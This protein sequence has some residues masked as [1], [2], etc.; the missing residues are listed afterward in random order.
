MEVKSAGLL[1]K[2]LTKHLNSFCAK[3]ELRLLGSNAVRGVLFP[4]DVDTQCIVNDL[5]ADELA[6]HIQSAVRDLGDAFITE[7][8]I[9]IEKT[10]Y[11]WS[12]AELLKG[13]KGSMSLSQALRQ[14]DGIVK[15]DMIIPVAEGFVDATINYIITLDGVTNITP[16]SKKDKIEE[17]KGEIEEYKKDNLFKALKRRFSILRLQGKNTDHILPFF[18][19]EVGLLSQIRNELE[20]LI[21]LKKRKLGFNRLSSFIQNIK[22]KLGLSLI[23]KEFLFKMNDWNDGNLVKNANSLIKIVLRQINQDTQTFLKIHKIK[24]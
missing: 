20:L 11:R 13:K 17:L 18:N 24:I 1:N 12:Q 16:T 2:K 8:K 10:K 21:E 7:F 22:H 6:K 15:C 9:T 5:S 19:S 14:A 23:D 3:S 4:A